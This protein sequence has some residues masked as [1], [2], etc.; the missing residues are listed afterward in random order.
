MKEGKEEEKEET[1]LFQILITSVTSNNSEQLCDMTYT[2]ARAG[3]FCMPLTPSYENM[4]F[5]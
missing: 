1:H 2:P 4:I 3:E 5:N